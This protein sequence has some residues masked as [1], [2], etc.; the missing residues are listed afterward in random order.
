MVYIFAVLLAAATAAPALDPGLGA[1]HWKVSTN[2]ARAQAYFDQ[3]MKYVYA[4]NHEQAV[5]SFNEATRRDPGLAMG[6]WGAAL[7]LGPSINM[8]VDPDREK[9]AY[10]AVQT[11]TQHLARASQKE[12]DLV[13][14]LAKRY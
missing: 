7:A 13:A 1:L 6:Y 11:A 9:E 2:D 5:R 4:F 8:D 10:D 14:A 12:R 3:G